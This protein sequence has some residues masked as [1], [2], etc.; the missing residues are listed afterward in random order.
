MLLCPLLQASFYYT[1]LRPVDHSKKTNSTLLSTIKI[2][3]FFLKSESICSNFFDCF[4][5]FKRSVTTCFNGFPLSFHIADH[6]CCKFF[7]S[8][9]RKLRTSCKLLQIFCIFLTNASLL[10]VQ[11]YCYGNSIHFGIVFCHNLIAT[12]NSRTLSTQFRTTAT[13]CCLF[14][15]RSSLV[16]IHVSPRKPNSLCAVSFDRLRVFICHPRIL[17]LPVPFFQ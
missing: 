12:S 5:F 8:L 17:I 1:G 14:P 11:M 7:S 15:V 16:G 9:S 2:C 6:I 4:H 10:L 13:N 3:P